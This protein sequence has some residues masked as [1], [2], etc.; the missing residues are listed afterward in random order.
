M[1]ESSK[2]S[3][4][5]DGT[6]NLCNSGI[7]TIS[8][9]ETFDTK[10][11]TEGTLPPSISYEAAMRDMH[12]VDETGRVYKG[13]DAVLRIA[14]VYPRL[15]WLGSIGRLPIIR[16]ILQGMYWIIARTRYRIFGRSLK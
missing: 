1:A 8:G 2:I 3:V 14:Q 15:R 4:Y 10:D 12:A 5:Y 6:C 7:R 11:V 9:N 16:Q 13:A